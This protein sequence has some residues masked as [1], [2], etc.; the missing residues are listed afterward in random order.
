MS[1][2]VTVKNGDF[3]YVVPQHEFSRYWLQHLDMIQVEKVPNDIPMVSKMAALKRGKGV[4][5][6]IKA[7]EQKGSGKHATSF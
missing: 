7:Y 1:R 2:T 6:V 5:R 3:Y 4:K